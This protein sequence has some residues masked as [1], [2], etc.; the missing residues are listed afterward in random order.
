MVPFATLNVVFAI[1]TVY[2]RKMA[3]LK[4]CKNEKYFCSKDEDKTDSKSL[5]TLI[6]GECKGV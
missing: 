1:Y 3:E 4:L 5:K 2:P 6:K